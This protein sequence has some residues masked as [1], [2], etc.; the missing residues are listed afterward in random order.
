MNSK[1]RNHICGIEPVSTLIPHRIN[2][3]I[4]KELIFTTLAKLDP[5]ATKNMG[6]ITA[7]LGFQTEEVAKER[8]GRRNSKE[9]FAK[10]NKS[11]KMEDNIRSKMVQGNLKVTKETMKKSKDEKIESD[12][13]EGDKK[14]NLTRT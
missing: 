13:N 7:G 12:T 2:Q 9:S 5:A 14:N 8:K 10:M 3:V 4:I 6:V 1:G 11:R